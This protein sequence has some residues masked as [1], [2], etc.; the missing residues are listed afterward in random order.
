MRDQDFSVS[1]GGSLIIPEHEVRVDYIKLFGVL[2]RERIDT[3]RQKTAIVTGG[4]KPTRVY[5]DALKKFG[6]QDPDILD[7]MGIHATHMN[8][9]LLTHALQAS[10][11]A[12]QYLRSYEDD[13][14]Q[15]CDAWITG[16]HHPGQT[17]DAVMVDW[18]A[19]LGIQTVINATNT[20]YIYERN[21]D[22]TLN[23]KRSIREMSWHDYQS[24][25]HGIGH[26]PGES[27]PFGYT[28]MEKAMA[29]NMI[30]VVLDGNDLPNLARVFDHKDS[31]VGTII[32]P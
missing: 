23:T 29:L 25:L 20:P 19:R 11:V 12:V 17:T 31:F 3:H 32:H 27:L 9:Y 21:P 30:A 26:T 4:G 1:I 14:D 16:G 24:M 6:I 15:S 10:G 2:L 5:Q 18:A 28:A 13:A 8:A 22:G 7:T